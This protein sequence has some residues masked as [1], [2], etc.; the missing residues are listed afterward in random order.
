M[1]VDRPGWY[2]ASR[3]LRKHYIDIFS[4]ALNAVKVRRCLSSEL[5]RW[6]FRACKGCVNSYTPLFGEQTPDGKGKH[7]PQESHLATPGILSTQLLLQK[8]ELVKP[9]Q[10][11]RNQNLLK[12]VSNSVPGWL[13][14]LRQGW[15]LGGLV[16]FVCL[17]VSVWCL[18]WDCYSKLF[19]ELSCRSLFFIAQNTMLP[20]GR[21]SFTQSKYHT[22]SQTLH[23]VHLQSH[24]CISYQ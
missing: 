12:E 15:Q 23:W 5:W 17:L 14:H 3:A 13:R 10:A 21:Q 22:L 16:H 8:L 24:M 11:I 1:P 9:L 2:F 7:S 4:M 20:H 6:H 18:S 19:F